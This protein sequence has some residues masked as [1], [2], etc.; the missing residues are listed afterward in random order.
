MLLDV[1]D[2]E[3]TAEINLTLLGFDV[4]NAAK[5]AVEAVSWSRVLR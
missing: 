3:K 2:A 4:I 1:E 5:T